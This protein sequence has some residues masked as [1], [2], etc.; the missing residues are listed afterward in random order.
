[1]PKIA[2]EYRSFR[3]DTQAI[4]DQ[5]ELLCR[6]YQQ[7]GYELTLRQLFYQFVSRGWVPNTDK[8]YKRLGSIVNDARLAG[9]IDWYHISD[10]TRFL[11]SPGSWESPSQIIDASASQ[12]TR[13]Y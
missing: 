4:I 6:Q 11:R 9:E 12:F 7:Q 1:M 5:A 10:R 3:S 2:Y 13:N 8:S